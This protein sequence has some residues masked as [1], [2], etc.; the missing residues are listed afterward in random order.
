MRVIGK[1][2]KPLVVIGDKVLTSHKGSICLVDLKSTD[3]EKYADLP[4]SGYKK[5]LS[6]IRIFERLFRTEARNGV[7]LSEHEV[8]FTFDGGIYHLDLLSRKIT[9]EKSF[10]NGMKNPLGLTRIVG[11]D[12]F[13]DCVVYG[14]Y[15]G[16]EKRS[17]SISLYS[18]SI[19]ERNW[20]KVYEFKPGTI[21]HIHG[22]KVVNG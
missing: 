3:C 2:Q 14:E 18:R 7:M 10:E 9:K 15:I 11:I 19:N 17:K 16:N 8:L 5:F 20:K 4:I 22:I 1:R 12:G 6:N 13:S 21:R